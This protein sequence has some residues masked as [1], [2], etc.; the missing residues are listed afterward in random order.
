MTPAA[1]AALAGRAS[2]PLVGLLVVGKAPRPALLAE[3]AR[4]TGEAELRMLGALDHLSDD[5][6]RARPP[7]DDAD[8][9]F[10]TLPD[11]STTLVSKAVVTE[12]MAARLAD[13]SA[14]GASAAVVCCTGRFAGLAAPGVHFASDLLAG[15][16]T[17]CLPRGGR[18]GV[19]IP[20]PAQA[21]NAVARWA[22]SGLEAVALP[23]SPDADADAIEA[24]ARAMQG[25]AP[26]LVA[27]DCISYT[28]AAR[29]RAAAIHGAPALLAASVAGRFAAELAGV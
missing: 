22:A 4:V 5:E 19:F 20:S 25:E 17:A 9:L 28:Q 6:V 10:T 2:A 24:A 23:L 29:A 11:G 8:T 27:M 14:M 7:R 3:I 12:G 16:V 1:D 26:D 15:A 21:A 13:L 18:L